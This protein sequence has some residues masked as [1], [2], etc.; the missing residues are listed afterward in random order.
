MG[1]V[2]LIPI[3]IPSPVDPNPQPPEGVWQMAAETYGGA[4]LRHIGIRT[5]DI[6]RTAD[7]YVSVFGL[8]RLSDDAGGRSL[9]LGDGAVNVTI[10]PLNASNRIMRHSPAAERWGQPAEADQDC[11]YAP[12][13]RQDAR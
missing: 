2:E 8:R 4:R 13:R 10:V 3:S 12:T 9:V 1:K 11:R 6:A 5:R 7:F